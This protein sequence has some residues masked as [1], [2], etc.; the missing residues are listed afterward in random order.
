MEFTFFRN[1]VGALGERLEFV[2]NEKV[3]DSEQGEE[4][5]FEENC[6][7]ERVELVSNEKVEEGCG[8]FFG[9]ASWGFT[10]FRNRVGALE[11]ERLELVS[12]EKVEVDG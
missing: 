11:E 6:E 3:E 10:F 4:L 5:L 12:N 1:R 2:S 7:E 8:A 9:G